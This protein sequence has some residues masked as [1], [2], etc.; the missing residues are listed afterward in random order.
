MTK[1]L[2]LKY[3]PQTLDD[4][5]G[6]KSTILSLKS[7]LHREQGPPKS[8][9][10]SGPSGCGKTTLAKILKKEFNCHDRD[11]H[12]YNTANT[13]GIDTIRDMGKLAQYSPLG[14]KVKFYLLDECHML[15]KDAQNALLLLLED[16]PAPVYF[17]LCTTNPEK[18]LDTIKTRCHK[19][20]VVSLTRNLML[21]LLREV[22]SKEFNDPFPDTILN[23]IAFCAQGSC[24]DALKMLDTVANIPDDDDALEAIRDSSVGETSTL[25][26]CKLLLN[27]NKNK[28]EELSKMIKTVDA[29]PEKLR[30]S[31]LGYLA[32]VLLNNPKGDD[33]IGRMLSIF[34]NDNMYSG[35]GGI[36][37]QLYLASK[38]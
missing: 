8:F 14:G 34:I 37:L 13:R 30:Y 6:N 16:P 1:D 27:G 15:T 24:R 4:I 25:E 3:R 2:A 12:Y 5:V 32:S 35:K 33:R 11:Y 20:P 36:V 17:A 19:F 31:I 21:K 7:V 29:E 9:L 22:I 23:E 10:F 38:L 26:I 18:L 28:W